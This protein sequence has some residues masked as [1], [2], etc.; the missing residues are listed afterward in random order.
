MPEMDGATFLEQAR[1][2]QSDTVRILLT[3]YS[4]MESTVKAINEGRIYTYLEKPWD[5]ERLK[6][7]LEKAAEH[8]LF[9]K[10]KAR[11]TKA[12]EVANDELATLNKSLEQK[13]L[14]RTKALKASEQKLSGNLLSQKA[15]LADVLDMLIATIEYRTGPDRVAYQTRG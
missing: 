14:Q 2:I 10:E 7:T 9:T 12:L 3:G 5:N 8:Y 11:L 15:F 1:K 4:D 6:L 13:V